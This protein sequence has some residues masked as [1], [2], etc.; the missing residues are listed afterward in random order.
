MNRMFFRIVSIFFMGTGLFLLGANFIGL[1]LG[2]N[3]WV[4]PPSIELSENHK[5]YN[6]H[7]AIPSIKMGEDPLSYAI[8]MTEWVNQHSCHWRMDKIAFSNIPVM[9]APFTYSWVLWSI[10]AF[11][12][13]T[14]S[15]YVLEFCNAEKALERGYGYCSQRSLILQDILRKQDLNAR[16]VK[17]NNHVILLFWPGEHLEYILD[18]DFNIVIPLPLQYVT[19]HPEIT[20]PLYDR[21]NKPETRNYYVSGDWQK[22][23]SKEYGCH[24]EGLLLYYSIIQWFVP[25]LLI[26][27]GLFLIRKK[28]FLI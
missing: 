13:L 23:G 18:P 14:N 20:Y 19:D 24:S 2:D 9:A 27:L 11:H 8:K 12:A 21:F 10:G 15:D 4:K 17:I 1:I 16:T 5:S 22:R 3:V 6:S 26:L 28:Y 25:V 7:A